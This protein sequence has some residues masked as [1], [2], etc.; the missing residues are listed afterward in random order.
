ME[1]LTVTEEFIFCFLN[2]DLS[3]LEQSK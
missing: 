3:I 1:F 2:V